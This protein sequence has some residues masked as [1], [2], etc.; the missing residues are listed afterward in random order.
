MT[1]L[2]IDRHPRSTGDP[3][4]AVTTDAGASVSAPASRRDST[5]PADKIP[6]RRL[7]EQHTQHKRLSDVT[8]DRYR[9]RSHEMSKLGRLTFPDSYPRARPGDEV[10]KAITLSPRISR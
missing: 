9:R 5:I 4:P 7:Y 8:R 6:T 2:H 10:D 1:H 3:F